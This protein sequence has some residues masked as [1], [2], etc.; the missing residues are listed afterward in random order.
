[1]QR[2]HGGSI[3]SIVPRLYYACPPQSVAWLACLLAWEERECC[4]VTRATIDL[5]LAAGHRV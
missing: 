3:E 4:S 1:M 2:S 5:Q